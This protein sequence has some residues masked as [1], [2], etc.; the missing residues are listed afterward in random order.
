[1]GQVTEET[2]PNQ[3][4]GKPITLEPEPTYMMPFPTNTNQK[5]QLTS[6]TNAPGKKRRKKRRKKQ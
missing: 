2:L 3:A 5:Q 1:M 6:G 4:I